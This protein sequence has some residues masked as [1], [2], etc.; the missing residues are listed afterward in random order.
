MGGHF[1]RFW[2][3]NHEIQGGGQIWGPPCFPS[4]C[5]SDGTAWTAWT[6]QVTGIIS[7]LG[8]DKAEITELPVKRWTQATRYDKMFEWFDI[9]L[10]ATCSKMLSNCL[11]NFDW[12]LDENVQMW[13]EIPAPSIVGSHV[14][15]AL[16]SLFDLRFHLLWC[17]PP[18]RAGRP[19][20]S[21]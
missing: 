14:F 11:I 2:W 16:L 1:T 12:T 19:R 5:I 20:F 7:H 9:G 6:A 10:I 8:D 4:F 18:A 15:G 17:R 13:H 21:W 3:P